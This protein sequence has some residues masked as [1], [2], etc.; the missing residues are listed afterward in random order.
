MRGISIVWF[1][2]CFLVPSLVSAQGSHIIKE[3][4][5]LLMN[6]ATG[7]KE[8]RDAKQ[9]R[10]IGNP[11]QEDGL[12]KEFQVKVYENSGVYYVFNF[13][14]VASGVVLD[15]KAMGQEMSISEFF[16]FAEL[17]ATQYNKVNKK[18]GR[19]YFS[20][21][22]DLIFESIIL[23]E[24]KEDGTSVYYTTENKNRS[25]MLCYREV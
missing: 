24:T 6:A 5:V 15:T 16:K 14:V 21:A 20:L 23:K 17:K 9:L 11:I 22:S 18:V 25:G 12:L 3:P 19:P 1:I 8:V 2:F 10:F 4:I 7:E 13:S